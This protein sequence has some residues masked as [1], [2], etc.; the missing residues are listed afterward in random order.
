[1]HGDPR[2]QIFGALT[3]NGNL[4][5]VA[6]LVGNDRRKTRHRAFIWG[7]YVTPAARGMGVG[8]RLIAACIDHARGIDGLLQVH[9]TV[10]S[11]NRAAMHLYER[12][13]F[14]RYGREPRS[15]LLPD[16]RAVDEDLMVLMLDD[17]DNAVP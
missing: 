16:G 12:L 10:A 13:G 9:L 4:I 2:N 17:E 14:S 8:H 11:H 1:M 3:H 5:G 7:V 6:G 15:I